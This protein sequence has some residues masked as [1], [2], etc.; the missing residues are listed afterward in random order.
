MRLDTIYYWMTRLIKSVDEEY[1]DDYSEIWDDFWALNKKVPV[2]IDY[3]DPDTS[4]KEDIMAR[5][6]AIGEY[7][8][9]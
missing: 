8:G 9:K 4:Y 6:N 7:I 3:Y 1:G 5:Y 2:F